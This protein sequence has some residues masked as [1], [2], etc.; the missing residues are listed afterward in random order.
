M[1]DPWE[2]NDNIKDH[3]THILQWDEDETTSIYR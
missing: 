2:S 1:R 3:P